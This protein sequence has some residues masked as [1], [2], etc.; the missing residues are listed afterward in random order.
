MYAALLLSWEGG[1]TVY[2]PWLKD[3]N[4][5]LMKIMEKRTVVGIS[6]IND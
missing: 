4:T 2:D 1:E 3:E 6:N 5:V